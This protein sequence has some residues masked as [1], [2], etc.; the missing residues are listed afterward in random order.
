MSAPRSRL[1]ALTVT[2]VVVSLLCI[3][4]GLWQGQRTRETLDLERASIAEPVA[5][6]EAADVDGFPAISVGRSAFASGTYASGQVYVGPRELEDRSGYWVLT[7]LETDGQTIAVLRGWVETP[8][9]GASAVPAGIVEVSGTLQPF[10]EFYA[11][12]PRD[13]DGQLVVVSRPEIEAEW[14]GP[15]ISLVLVLAEQDPTADPAPAPVTPTVSLGEVPFPWQN[16]AYTIQWFVFAG[17]VWV[18]WWMWAI[19]GR[20]QEAD[21]DSLSE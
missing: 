21:A 13:P 19:R 1:A 7:P 20:R 8:E 11:D 9:D 14:G 6:L 17:F 12:R 5:V 2:A 16:A 10:E 15:V 3:A 18:M 4:A